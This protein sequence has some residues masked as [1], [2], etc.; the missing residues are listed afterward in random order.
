MLASLVSRRVASSRHPSP[1]VQLARNRPS[2]AR[3]AGCKFREAATARVLCQRGRAGRRDLRCTSAPQ[4]ADLRFC[5]SPL[6]AVAMC[7]AG[8]NSQPAF[9]ATRARFRRSRLLLRRRE[10]GATAHSPSLRSA[11][12]TYASARGIT[13]AS[14]TPGGGSTHRRGRHPRR[15]RFRGGAGGTRPFD[16]LR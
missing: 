3:N 1:C 4:A 14:G 15:F 7:R 10:C 2:V 11:Q 8:A 13:S 12:C 6:R 16:L 5:A 9:L